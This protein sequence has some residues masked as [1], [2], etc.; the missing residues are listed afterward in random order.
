M[1]VEEQYYVLFAVLLILVWRFGKDRAFWTVAFL[2]WVSLLLSEWG[3]RHDA[4]ANFYL[5]P[6]RAWEIFAGSIAAFIV[7]EKGVRKNSLMSLLGL[8]A[9][10]FS[11][12]AY[13]ENTPF[14]SVYALLPVLGVVL[15]ILYGGKDTFA[16]RV[17]SNRAF[18]GIG[19]ISY[20]AYLCHQPLFAFARIRLIGQPSEVLMLVLSVL[21]LALAYFSWK[22]VETPFRNRHATF[23]SKGFIFS[24]SIIGMA[25]FSM[26]GFEGDSNNGYKD[27]FSEVAFGDVGHLKYHQFID[28]K[29]YDCEP[30]DVAKMRC[31]GKALFAASN[32]SRESL[33]GCC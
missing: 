23:R 21:S 5:A 33:I 16:A 26:L 19:L 10:L 4:T 29:F 17:L 32:Q 7:Q 14:P 12:F 24:F 31:H 6:M 2:A 8:G 11:I 27:R 1:A 22:F 15:I 28:E 18:V 30:D 25:A 13:D 3:W 9:V 20:S